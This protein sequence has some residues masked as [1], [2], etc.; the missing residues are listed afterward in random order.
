LLSI[1]GRIFHQTHWAPLLKMQGS[2]AEVKLE[3]LHADGSK[4]PMM[5]NALVRRH[6]GEEFHELA[7]FS[8]RDR[9]QYERELL[10]ARQRAE[11][12][13]RREQ[14]SQRELAEARVRLELALDA[15]QL[16]QWSVDLPA[17]ERRYA[18]EVA[19][20]LGHA[21]AR[22]V[23]AAAFLTCI[24]PDDREREAAALE[25]FLDAGG[26]GERQHT[27]FRLQGVD[28][29]ERWVAAWG[30]LRLN[31]AGAPAAFVGVLQDV[32]ASQRQRAIAEDRAL[33]AE[34]TLGIVGHDLR[35][36]LFAIQ[37][38]AD[39]LAR[40][41]LGAEQQQAV[42]AR[43]RSS[44]GRATRLIADLLDFTQARN[45]RALSVNLAPV[46]VHA[47]AREV[48]NELSV[49]YKTDR[50][51][52]VA[53]GGS[54]ATADADRLSQAIGN[55][56]ANALHYGRPDSPVTV[57]SVGLAGEVRLTVHNEGSAIDA[58]LLPRIFEPMTRGVDS[59]DLRSVGLGLFIVREI[60]MAHGGSVECHSDDASG[61]T[62]TIRLPA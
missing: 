18:P 51:R 43:I 22:P 60:A 24:H 62:F 14:E 44:T 19:L 9:H 17:R 34:Q 59:G 31:A 37:M 21:E 35:N 57:M 5:M 23:D 61:T 13:L 47:V 49:A 1:G 55:L 2:L 40:R 11:D 48:V 42:V 36:P 7:V 10:N 58:K 52:H 4:L 27:V 39:T 12:L 53:E 50:L 3:V 16:S 30:R 56:V 26:S 33:L 29:V 28:G 32:T 15:A 20:L 38:S 54:R 46:D 6:E 25:T 45:G 8:A 41:T